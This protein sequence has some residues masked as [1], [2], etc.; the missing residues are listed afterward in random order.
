MLGR[1]FQSVR[2]FGPSRD[3]AVLITDGLRNEEIKTCQDSFRGCSQMF[4]RAKDKIQGLV[5]RVST[6]VLAVQT[7]EPS[8]TCKLVR[9]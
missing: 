1:L 7:S 9:E 5:K 3:V 8:C 4:I 2:L 6:A